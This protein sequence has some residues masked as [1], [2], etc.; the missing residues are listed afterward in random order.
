MALYSPYFTRWKM[1]L[2]KNKSHF[3][4]SMSL[5]EES[6]PFGDDAGVVAWAVVEPVETSTGCLSPCWRRALDYCIPEKTYE[7]D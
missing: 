3:D 1:E 5:Q 2:V 6:A 7:H 4:F